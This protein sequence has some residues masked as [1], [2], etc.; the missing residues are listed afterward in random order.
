M[1]RAEKGEKGT[2]QSQNDHKSLFFLGDLLEDK[3]KIKDCLNES[4]RLGNLFTSC[5]SS[6]L[7]EG[8]VIVPKF[9]LAPVNCEHSASSERGSPWQP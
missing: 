3:H 9:G 7:V 6:Y 8:Q 2:A 4:N 5:V 1:T